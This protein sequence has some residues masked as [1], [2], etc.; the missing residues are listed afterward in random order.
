[1]YEQIS[2]NTLKSFREF[3]NRFIPTEDNLFDT[4]ISNFEYKKVARKEFYLRREKPPTKFSFYPKD[5]SV[6]IT[7]KMM[8]P[9]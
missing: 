8:E 4:I 2:G 6:S 9:K 1:M 7:P 5:L 3:V